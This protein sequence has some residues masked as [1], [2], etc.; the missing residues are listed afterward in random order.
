MQNIETTG[1]AL[2]LAQVANILV[3][4]PDE[5][6]DFVLCTPFLRGL[7]ASAPRA[8]IGLVT[9]AA[10]ADLARACPHVDYVMGPQ[11]SAL[12]HSALAGHGFDLAVVPRLDFDRYG[13]AVVARQ[14]RAA[15]V[16]GFSE[17]CT[18]LKAQHNRGFDRRYYTDVLARDL[19]AHEVEHNLALLQHMGGCPQ[20]DA[21]ELHVSIENGLS[22]DRVIGEAAARLG[23]SRIIAVAPRVLVSEQGAAARDAGADRRP[24]CRNA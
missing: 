10:V 17:R 11:D 23:R 19:A 4:K 14:S 22:A 6:G 20:G 13:A 9:S 12:F 16:F 24:C 5:I 7:R 1:R 18:P 2:D 21:V 8:S 15:R 3:V